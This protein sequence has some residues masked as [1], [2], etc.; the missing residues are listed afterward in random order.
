MNVI[1]PKGELVETVW[2]AAPR[3]RRTRKG[4][5]R[6]LFSSQKAAFYLKL[7]N[8]WSQLEGL[9]HSDLILDCGYNKQ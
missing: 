9:E 2:R 8:M 5:E 7:K 4:I 1:G 3:K 6:G